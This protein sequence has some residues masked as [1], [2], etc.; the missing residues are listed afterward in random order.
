ML[1]EK[2]IPR[3]PAKIKK[4]IGVVLDKKGQNIVIIDL[5]KFNHISDFFVIC[6]SESSV[7]TEAII[8]ELKKLS[9]KMKRMKVLN[10]EFDKNSKWNVVDFGDV[11]LHIFDKEGRKFYDLE[12]LWADA[13]KFYVNQ[14][15]EIKE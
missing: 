11:I 5:R 9:K 7:Q 8:Y 10:I 2:K 3:I 1:K 12:G 14:N 15:G 4:I 13:R 6:N